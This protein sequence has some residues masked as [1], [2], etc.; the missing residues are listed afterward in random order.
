MTN[1]NGTEEKHNNIRRSEEGGCSN[2][3]LFVRNSL[4]Q[5]NKTKTYRREC[6]T[7]N[8]LTTDNVQEIVTKLI[9]LYLQFTFSSIKIKDLNCLQ[10]SGNLSGL[11]GKTQLQN[12]KGRGFE[13][14]PS[15][16]AR[17]FVHKSQKSTEYTV[18][19]HISVKPKLIFSI[20]DAI[21]HLF[22]LGPAKSETK[23][24]HTSQVRHKSVYHHILSEQYTI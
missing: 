6:K 18:L 9:N 8:E 2:K 1:D 10:L 15:K 11:V 21:F 20:P 13:S 14:H 17:D 5:Q 3:P 23:R 12:R 19:K 7:C 22:K 16:Y 4:R 24:G